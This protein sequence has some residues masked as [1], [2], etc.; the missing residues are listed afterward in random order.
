MRLYQVEAVAALPRMV[1]PMSG[2]AEPIGREPGTAGTIMFT[3]QIELV[4]E[5]GKHTSLPLGPHYA[6]L[7]SKRY[8]WIN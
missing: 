3:T 1:V 6:R 4:R 5:M 7:H 2:L 8:M